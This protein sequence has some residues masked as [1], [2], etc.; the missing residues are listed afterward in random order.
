MN[1]A[2]KHSLDP[3]Q[4]RANI[5]RRHSGRL[6]RGGRFG[7]LWQTVSRFNPVVCLII[8]LR[9]TFY[10]AVDVHIAVSTGMTLNFLVDSLAVVRWVFKTGWRIR[11]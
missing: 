8:G 2:H 3:L 10:G 1:P 9:W 7:P 5:G 11:R 6:R 4:Q